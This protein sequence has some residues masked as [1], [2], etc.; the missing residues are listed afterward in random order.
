MVAG[1]DVPYEHSRSR[2]F[3]ECVGDLMNR[4]LHELLRLLELHDYWQYGRIDRKLT[5]R[6]ARLVVEVRSDSP[7]GYFV[8]NETKRGNHGLASP[9]YAK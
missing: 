9:R 6:I 2:H 5:R 1:L 3:L 7:P 8:A 4:L